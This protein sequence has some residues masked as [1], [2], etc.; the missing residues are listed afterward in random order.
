M[1]SQMSSEMLREMPR[2]FLIFCFF[3]KYPLDCSHNPRTKSS[4]VQYH[5]ALVHLLHPLLY[6]ENTQSSYEYLKDLLIRQARD[7]FALIVQHQHLYTFMYQ[8]PLQLP[9]FVHL[10]DVL[11]QY[12]RQNP[13]TP[14]II[15]FCFESLEEAK[16]SY[17]IAGPLQQMFRLS[18]AEYNVPVPSDLHRL[19][20]HASRYGPEDFLNTC[21]RASYRQPINQ[22]LPNLDPA[23]GMEFVQESQR[24]EEDGFMSSQRSQDSSQSQSESRKQSL[25]R[26]ESVLNT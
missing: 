4:S 14:D 19:I 25:M 18:L 20:G 5:T 8:S 24:I 17:S 9:C 2:H 23:L 10:C 15:R 26:I 1:S 3:S 22:L 12:D 16:A 21:T 7:G 13:A 6:L 11:V